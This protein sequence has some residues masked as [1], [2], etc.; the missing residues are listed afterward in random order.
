MKIMYTLNIYKYNCLYSLLTKGLLACIPDADPIQSFVFGVRFVKIGF[1]VVQGF[2]IAAVS[3]WGAFIVSLL[4][5]AVV[6]VCVVNSFIHW[7][8]DLIG[9]V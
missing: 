5:T 3:S 9:F 1:A 2:G 6:E 4:L 8:L 7:F